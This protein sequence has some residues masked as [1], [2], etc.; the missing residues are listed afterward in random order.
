MTANIWNDMWQHYM[1]IIITTIFWQSYITA[2]YTNS[3]NKLRLMTQQTMTG[4]MKKLHTLTNKWKSTL[5]RIKYT[6]CP[7]KKMFHFNFGYNS[8]ISWSIFIILIPLSL[9]SQY[10]LWKYALWKKESGKVYT[11]VELQCNIS[12]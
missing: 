3:A 2:K 9:F 8:R 4:I 11:V 10:I 7:E 5:H 1:L 12:S 6:E